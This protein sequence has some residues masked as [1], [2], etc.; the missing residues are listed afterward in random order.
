LF[1]NLVLESAKDS[2]LVG[3]LI[4]ELTE[5]PPPIRGEAIPFLGETKTFE[6]ILGIAAGG[7]IVL[8][9]GGTWIGCRAE[10]A[11]DEDSLRY[12]RLNAF[13]VG[14]E[15]RKIQLGLPGAV[16]GGTVTVPDDHSDDTE[17]EAAVVIPPGA[18]DVGNPFPPVTPVDGGIIGSAGEGETG[19]IV[20]QDSLP[21]T[22]NRKSVEPASGIN[23]SGCFESWGIPSDQ[24]IEST[25]IEFAGLTAQQ[26][27]QILQR[28]P[29]TFKASMDISYKEGD[30]K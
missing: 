21:T 12:M 15:M 22:Q 10:D 27:R 9:K 28:I 14:Q 7:D 30:Q 24:T 11:S 25:R 16:G 19:W 6:I 20:P 13:C 18:T 4:D 3:S 29:S 8:N 26:I 1:K 23:L 17:T 5:P 2:D